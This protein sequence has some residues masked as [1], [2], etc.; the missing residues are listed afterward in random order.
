M[1]TAVS[2]AIPTAARADDRRFVGRVVVVGD[3]RCMA[4]VEPR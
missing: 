2:F 3:G 1:I 4:E